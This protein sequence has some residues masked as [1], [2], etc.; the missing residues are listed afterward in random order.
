LE[1]VST[2][3][4]ANLKSLSIPLYE[5]GKRFLLPLTVFFLPRAGKGGREGFYEDV[6]KPLIGAAAAFISRSV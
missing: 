6:F 1:E 3:R 5:R 4:V 2:V